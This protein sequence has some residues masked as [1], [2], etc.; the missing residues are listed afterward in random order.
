MRVS[1]SKQGWARRKFAKEKIGTFEKP[2]SLA[3]PSAGREALAALYMP[4]AKGEPTC[5]PVRKILTRRFRLS[6]LGAA[7][8][9]LVRKSGRGRRVIGPGEVCF[10]DD[11]PQDDLAEKI[12]LS[13]KLDFSFSSKNREM[14][15]IV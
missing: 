11:E 10:S 14:W 15:L 12:E 2:G 9:R 7:L 13:T 8:P 3:S 4:G 1:P 5:Y 6:R